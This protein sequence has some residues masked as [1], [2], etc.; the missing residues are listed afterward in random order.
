MILSF[1]KHDVKE[2][3]HIIFVKFGSTLWII[4]TQRGYMIL[5]ARILFVFTLSRSQI[6]IKL[7]ITFTTQ[8]RPLNC[9][10]S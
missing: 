9:R 3:I 6:T 10:N 5:F 4:G 2:F 1:R 7:W 8:L